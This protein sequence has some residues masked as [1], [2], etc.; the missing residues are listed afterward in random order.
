MKYLQC[1]ERRPIPQVSITHVNL[2]RWLHGKQQQQNKAGQQLK[3]FILFCKR[4]LIY[5]SLK[6]CW[7]EGA[8]ER[9]KG[10]GGE[11]GGGRGGRGG[12]GSEILNYY[13]QITI[14]VTRLS[15][16]CEIVSPRGGYTLI[17]STYTIYSYMSLIQ[18]LYQ[19]VTQKKVQAFRMKQ[20]I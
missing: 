20:I 14:N 6:I 9:G 19:M 3:L 8:R 2:L 11:G 15:L 16:V 5:V 7:L 17:Q 18:Y 13:Y 1:A 12:R 10:D 4:G